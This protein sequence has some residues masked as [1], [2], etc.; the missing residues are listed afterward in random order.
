MLVFRDI[1]ELWDTPFEGGRVLCTGDPSHPDRPRQFSV[2]LIDCE[3]LDW[4]VHDIVAGLDR[5]DY[6]Y[7][8]LLHKFCLLPDEQIKPSLSESWNSLEK[9]DPQETAL[10]H[11]TDMLTQP[12]VSRKNPHGHLWIETFREAV[13]SG[14]ISRQEVQLA[15]DRKFVRPTLLSD[16]N[17][18]ELW[19]Y[20]QDLFHKPHR[21]YFKH[22]KEQNQAPA[23]SH[24]APVAG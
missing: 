7:G 8:E 15:V 6:D 11:Y 9:Y 20:A 17:R 12:Y 10:L 4:D 18:W 24:G 14:F 16:L 21:K 19:R 23:A 3:N 22:L 5:G 1:A 13:Q 2:M